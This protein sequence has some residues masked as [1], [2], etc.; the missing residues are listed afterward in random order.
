V[1]KPFKKHLHHNLSID[2]LF[3][4]KIRLQLLTKLLL[5]P[6]TKVFLRG[7]ER[8]L[9][10]S[11]NTIRIE[12][13]KLSDMQLIEAQDH[14]DGD[15]AKL[16]QYGANTKH[17]LFNSLRGIILQH[18]G[19]DKIVDSIL[20]RLGN[21]DQVWLTGDLAEGKDSPFVDLVI[22]GDIEKAYLYQLIEKVEPQINKK[23]RVAV[24]CVK[25]FK[26][27]VMK[28]GGVVMRLVG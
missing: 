26:E 6:S 17:P 7:L 12:L 9:G 11:S 3:S 18:V 15:N 21:V 25:E 13:I 23:I 22:V 5:N 28:D 20:N 2:K 27:G 24:Y 16:K 1:A 19:L 14:Q 4:G 10:V 8:D